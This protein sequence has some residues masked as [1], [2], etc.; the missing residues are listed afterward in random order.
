[1]LRLSAF[2]HVVPPGWNT[3]CLPGNQ[4]L[5]STDTSCPL[6]KSLTKSS[7]PSPPNRGA[8]LLCYSHTSVIVLFVF[9][10][11]SNITPG[12][13]PYL[14]RLCIPELSRGPRA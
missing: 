3:S 12:L 6:W 5:D 9:I 10:Y 4:P 14:V 1:M 13:E 8:F 2:A 11:T 7:E